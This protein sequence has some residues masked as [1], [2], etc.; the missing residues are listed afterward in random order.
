LKTYKKNVDF[1][2]VTLDGKI[3]RATSS[4]TSERKA[5]LNVFAN[6][7]GIVIEHQPISKTGEKITAREVLRGDINLEG[8]LVLADAIH[9]DRAMLEELKKKEPRMSSLLKEIKAL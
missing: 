4:D 9:T 1:D 8:K 2:T 3:I 6:E 7:L 5:F